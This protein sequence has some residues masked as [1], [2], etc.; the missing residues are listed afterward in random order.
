LLHRMFASPT[1]DEHVPLSVR[2][3]YESCIG[4]AAPAASSRSTR[5]LNV[6]GVQNWIQ[7]SA[8][9]IT[10]IKLRIL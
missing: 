9:I 5:C 2:V 1:N 3:C 4:K 6:Y 8:P 10:L 7:L